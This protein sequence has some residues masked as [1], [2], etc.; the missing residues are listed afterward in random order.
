MNDKSYLLFLFSTKV[1]LDRRVTVSHTLEGHSTIYTWRVSCLY[2][3]PSL[4]L[5]ESVEDLDEVWVFNT[6]FHMSQAYT[7][8]HGVKV[9]GYL[10]SLAYKSQEVE[11]HLERYIFMV[12]RGTHLVSRVLLNYYEISCFLS[13]YVLFSV[14]ALIMMLFIMK[15]FKKAKKNDV[16]NLRNSIARAKL[17]I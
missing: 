10:C 16:T 14:C 2:S 7:S 5:W 3:I 11:C 1:S 13:H 17:H 12:L 6:K 9:A 4:I 15:L 8:C